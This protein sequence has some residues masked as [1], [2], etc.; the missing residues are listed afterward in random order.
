MEKFLYVELKL[1]VEV[2]FYLNQQRY[3]REEVSIFAK[4]L[5][6]EIFRKQEKMVNY[7]ME[8]VNGPKVIDVD[9]KTRII[10]NLKFL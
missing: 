5:H 10:E 3:Y 4:K 6:K 9:P 2:N 7:Y 1:K 8:Q